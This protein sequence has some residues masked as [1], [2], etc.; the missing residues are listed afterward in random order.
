MSIYLLW[1]EDD[2][3]LSKAVD[4]LRL[5]VLHPDWTSFNYDKISPEP[6]DGVILALN[7]V[8]TAPFGVGRRLVWLVDTTL[9]Q[10]CSEELLAQLE[11]TLPVIPESSVLLL[12]TR[13]KPDGRLKSTKLLQQYAKVQEF[14]LIP[15]WKTEQLLQLVRQGSQEVGVK[16]TNAAAKLLA[17]LVGNDTRQ[18][19]N[20]LEKLKL[21]AGT[22]PI[23]GRVID[24]KAVTALV[25]CNTQNSLQLANA[26]RQGNQETALV[27]VAEL[28]AHNE[29]ALK[30]VATLSGQFRTW[31]WVKLM[32]ESGEGD[33]KAIASAAE[34]GNPKRVYFLRQEVKFLS[35]Q[36]LAS[37]LLVLLELESSLKRGGEPLL[38]LQT[39]VIEL[40][41]V[42]LPCFNPKL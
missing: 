19:F 41:Q 25:S 36:R 13:T 6:A 35:A 9:C 15:P 38:T 32:I 17:E 26:I 39:K 40:C 31:L 18:L 23:N 20:E 33:D 2:F 30:I 8:M 4:A 27:L 14:S 10:H 16:L 1:G 7:Q 28:M 21:Y 11:R 42:V 5:S 34:V 3:A 24:D 37:T 29:P 12:T 22:S